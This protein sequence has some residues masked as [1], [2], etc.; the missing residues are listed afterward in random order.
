MSKILVAHVD[1]DAQAL[2]L[3][4]RAMLHQLPDMELVEVRSSSQLRDLIG[5]RRPDAILLDFNL[6]DRDGLGVL[7]DLRRD[8]YEGAVI[9]VTGVGSEKVAVEAMKRGAT[10]YLVKTPGY[11]LHVPRAILKVIERVRLEKEVAEAHASKHSS[12]VKE[13]SQRARLTLATEMVNQIR[14]PLEAAVEELDALEGEIGLILSTPAS[15]SAGRANVQLLLA[16]LRTE[17]ERLQ[18]TLE[19]LQKMPDP[20]S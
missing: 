13:A 7:R 6:P 20:S 19:H 18:K 2:I 4:R 12:D 10:D 9:F 1:D 5:T 3:V 8:G 14:E 15:L 16:Q 11:E 17:F